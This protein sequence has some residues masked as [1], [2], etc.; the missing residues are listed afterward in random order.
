M[1]RWPSKPRREAPRTTERVSSTSLL[2]LAQQ[3]RIRQT[4]CGGKHPDS[5]DFIQ[6][7][8]EAFTPELAPRCGEGVG[9]TATGGLRA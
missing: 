1:L 6:E 9:A 4:I 7:A 8:I 3:L 2:G 5:D